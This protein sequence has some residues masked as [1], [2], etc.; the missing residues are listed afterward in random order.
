MPGSAAARIVGNQIIWKEAIASRPV[1]YRRMQRVSQE[2]R[3]PRE[4]GADAETAPLPAA[5]HYQY[6]SMANAAP[7]LLDRVGHA[8]ILAAR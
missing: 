3:W 4:H 2:E 1:D 5:P 6:G 7:P 8:R